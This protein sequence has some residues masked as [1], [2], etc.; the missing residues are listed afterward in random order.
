MERIPL[1]NGEWFDKEK[2][3]SWKAA[4]DHDGS[5]LICRATG[6]QWHHEVLLRTASGNWVLHEWSNYQGSLDI[7]TRISLDAATRW[8]IQN[9][10][11]PLPCMLV[12]FDRLEV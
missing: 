6:C 7:Y 1:K 12:M 9:G 4:Y 2:C 5:N 10:R 8:F 11:E 3:E